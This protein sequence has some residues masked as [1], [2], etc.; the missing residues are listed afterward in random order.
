MPFLFNRLVR[1]H[2]RLNRILECDQ[3]ERFPIDARVIHGQNLVARPS[4][5]TL[6]CSHEDATTDIDV[7]I[8]EQVGKGLS[9]CTD[10]FMGFIHDTQVERDVRSAS[11]GRD[12]LPALIGGE[13]DPRAAVVLARRWTLAPVQELRDDVE[14]LRRGIVA[15]VAEERPY[16]DLAMLARNFNEMVGRGDATTMAGEASTTFKPS[17]DPTLVPDERERAEG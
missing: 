1:S 5:A 15:S 13:D 12:G 8:V 7:L 17:V 9:L 2:L 10:R 11:S 4:I 14:A 3:V 16:S 6:R